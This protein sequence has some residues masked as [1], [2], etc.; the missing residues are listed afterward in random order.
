METPSE[1]LRRAR[2]AKGFASAREAARHF[3]WNEVTY[4]T[5]ENG[6]RGLRVSTARVY[7][8]A[9]GVP[10][11]EL[12]GIPSTEPVPVGVGIRVIGEA[13]IGIWRDAALQS[14]DDKRISIPDAHPIERFAVRIVDHAVDKLISKDEYA[15]CEPATLD[16]IEPGQIVVLRRFRQGLTEISVRRVSEISG[17]TIRATGH[18]SDNRYAAIV[19]ITIGTDASLVGRVIAKYAEFNL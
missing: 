16:D 15:V 12:V 9:F 14:N 13:A 4:I 10:V 18:S 8:K 7:A 5:H 1:R 2:V 19:D 17:K 6:T 3:G 11:S